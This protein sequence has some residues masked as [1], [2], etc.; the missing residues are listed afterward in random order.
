MPST[1]VCWNCG[2]SLSDIPLPISRH[3]TCQKCREVL[4]CCRMCEYYKI[5]APGNCDHDRADPP[6]RKESANFCGFFRY[7]LS[8]YEP[9]RTTSKDSAEKQLDA[10][11]GD[12]PA[13]RSGAADPDRDAMKS[14]LD[15]LF[16]D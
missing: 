14:R 13:P 12:G 8:A 9:R 5:D 2:G 3:E 6:A 11:F 16:D 1:L 7:K 10:L 15:D 4:H